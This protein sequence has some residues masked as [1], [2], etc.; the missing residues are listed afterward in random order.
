MEGKPTENI[1]DELDDSMVLSIQTLLHLNEQRAEDIADLTSPLNSE[2]TT[3]K[4]EVIAYKTR[5]GVRE[6]GGR[7]K[8]KRETERVEA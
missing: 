1:V 2:S 4:C 8:R 5:G 6:E 3:S 7:R